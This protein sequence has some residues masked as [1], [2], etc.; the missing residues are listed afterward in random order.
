MLGTFKILLLNPDLQMVY[1][2]I[3]KDIRIRSQVTGEDALKLLEE[4]KIDLILYQSA[5]P[6]PFDEQDKPLDQAARLF[7]GLLIA[8][9]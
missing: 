3:G 5:V 6:L 1:L 4:E 7:N 2:V 9:T 8:S